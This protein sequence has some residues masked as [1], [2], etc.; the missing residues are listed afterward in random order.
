MED[1]LKLYDEKLEE[2]PKKKSFMGASEKVP[3]E[4]PEDRGDVKLA[5][6]VKQENSVAEKAEDKDEDD[7]YEENEDLINEIYNMN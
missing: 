4:L 5:P 6:T 7:E 1:R 3:V 2:L